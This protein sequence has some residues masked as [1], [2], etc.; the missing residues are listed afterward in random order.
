VDDLAALRAKH[1]RLIEAEVDGVTLRFRPLAGP[2]ASDL[3]RRMQL[4]PELAFDL[5]LE[6]CESACLSGASTF[7]DLA[8]RFPLAFAADDGV[9]GRLL[10]DADADA[11]AIVKAG[12]AR[13]RRAERNLGAQADSL[14]A[15]LSYRGG[16]VSEKQLAGALHLA[17]ALE[18]LPAL[19]RLH[20]NFFKALARR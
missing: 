10:A 18:T 20:L 5:A 12:I 17:Q 6:V 19:F 15:L 1:G 4:A 14:L 13:W 8:D 16:E 11:R 7:H 2:E 3:A 9:C